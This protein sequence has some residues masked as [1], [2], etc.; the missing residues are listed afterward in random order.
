MFFQDKTPEKTSSHVRAT[1]NFLVGPQE[2]FLIPVKSRKPTWF[3]QV[4]RHDN[5]SKTILQ[6]IL[7]DGRR[8]GRQKKCQTDNINEWTSLP[9]SLIH[10]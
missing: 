8:R 1:I 3:G 9:L 2:S 6:D 4:T 10:I 5:L 7:E